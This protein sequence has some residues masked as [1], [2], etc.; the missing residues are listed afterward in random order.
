[1]EFVQRTH[2]C[3]QCNKKAFFPQLATKK[4]VEQDYNCPRCGK[5]VISFWEELNKRFVIPYF[6]GVPFLSM[7]AIYGFW[8]STLYQIRS[9]D[10]FIIV[11]NII[12]AGIFT[13]YGVRYSKLKNIPKSSDKSVETLKQFR[14]QTIFSFLFTFSG[15]L[16]ATTIDILLVLIW[17]GIDKIT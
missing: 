9:V 16:F 12:I 1:M 13:V 8:T 6:I 15:F 5:E 17:L 3:N 7:S 4:T 14:K 10:I 11:L 2:Y